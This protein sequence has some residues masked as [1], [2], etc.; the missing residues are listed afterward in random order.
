MLHYVPPLVANC[1]SARCHGADSAQ[2]VFLKPFHWKQQ[3]A[4]AENDTMTRQ[5]NNE[6]NLT[7]KLNQVLILCRFI[8]TSGLFHIVTLFPHY[9]N[10]KKILIIA[11]SSLDNTTLKAWSL[12]MAGVMV[13]T[14]KYRSPPRHRPGKKQLLVPVI[15]WTC[16]LSTML[17][18]L[19]IH[20]NFFPGFS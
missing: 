7:I 13:D 14:N 2:W 12:I 20:F 17:G 4:V 10:N 18:P 1:L 11:T 6:L 3:P 8:T 9:Q 16:H 19:E 5:L 15:Q